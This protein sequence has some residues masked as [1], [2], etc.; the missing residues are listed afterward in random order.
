MYNEKNLTKRQVRVL[1]LLSD[2]K[3]YSVIE[4]A[5]TLFIGDPR[6]LIRDLRKDGIVVKDE[7]ITTRDGKGRYKRY[8]VE[9]K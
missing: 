3:H 5:N 2:G 7:W 8:W 4:I 1:N 9:N 6:S